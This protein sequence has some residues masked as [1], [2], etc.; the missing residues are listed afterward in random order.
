[1][2]YNKNMKFILIIFTLFTQSCVIYPALSVKGAKHGTVLDIKTQEPVKDILVVGAISHTHSVYMS[3]SS[4]GH[5]VEKYSI[6]DTQGN[7]HI[8]SMVG[9]KI[10][11]AIPIFATNKFGYSLWSYSKHYT[12]ERTE[13]VDNKHIIYVSKS[14]KNTSNYPNGL[15][16]KENDFEKLKRILPKS[17]WSKLIK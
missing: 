7:F 10:R 16:Y 5:L 14:D 2:L 9:G 3:G 17:Q 12:F 13:I 6:T 4:T 15:K 8:S 1:M 11:S